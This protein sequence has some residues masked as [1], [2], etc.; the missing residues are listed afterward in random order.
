MTGKILL[1]KLEESKRREAF[2][3]KCGP[4]HAVNTA[5]EKV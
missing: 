2:A 5:P 1:Q 3:D 4:S